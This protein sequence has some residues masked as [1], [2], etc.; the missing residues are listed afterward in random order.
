MLKKRAKTH[1]LVFPQTIG[2]NN[3]SLVEKNQVF[4]KATFEFKVHYGLYG[5]KH[6]VVTTW[7]KLFVLD[8]KTRMYDT[9]GSIKVFFPFTGKC[10]QVKWKM[11]L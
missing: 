3:I 8:G 9:E 10:V 1:R 4:K 2:S 6:Q 7:L 11:G 5:G